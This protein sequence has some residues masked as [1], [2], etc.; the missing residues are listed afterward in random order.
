[1][2]ERMKG[3]SYMYTNILEDILY[4]R[5]KMKEYK[6]NEN[7]NKECYLYSVFACISYCGAAHDVIT[8]SQVFEF[9]WKVKKGRKKQS[10]SRIPF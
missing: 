1:M 7:N 3:I 9:Y 4:E 6:I 5:Q 8:D 10:T 2:R